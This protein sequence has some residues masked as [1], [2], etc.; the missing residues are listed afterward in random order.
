MTDGKDTYRVLNGR[1]A[2]LVREKASKFIGL[3]FPVSTADDFKQ[4]LASIRKE[5]HSARHWCY[6]YVLGELGDVHRSNDDGEP[7]GTAGRPILRHIQG[8]GLTYTAVVVVRY[9]G[10]T[11][12]GKGGLV[13]AYGDAAQQALE[14]APSE[15]RHMLVGVV[16]TCTHAQFEQVRAD[17]ARA[18]GRID[19]A[20][21][22]I[23][24]SATLSLPRSQVEPLLRRWREGGIA[25]CA[26]MA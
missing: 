17:V 9:F 22:D 13:Q 16:L 4:E 3:A 24:C 21:F 14:Q 7:S 23:V 19:S 18:C 12:L 8:A 20:T 11:L 15:L 2:S 10:G 25:H 26:P 1:S 6:A 5:H